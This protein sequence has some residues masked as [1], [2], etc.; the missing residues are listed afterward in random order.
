MDDLA[1]ATRHAGNTDRE[2][3]AHEGLAPSRAP[4]AA[5]LQARIEAACEQACNTIAPTWPLDRS[6]AVNPH[7][8]RTALPVRRVAARMAVLADIQVFPPRDH[9]RRA[10]EEGRRVIWISVSGL[11]KN[12]LIAL[13]LFSWRRKMPWIPAWECRRSSR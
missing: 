9:L 2:L 4:A 1:F 5:D 10:W 8:A 11:A 12:A 13:E 6:I 7:W 3:P